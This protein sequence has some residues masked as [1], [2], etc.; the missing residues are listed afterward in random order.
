MS[1]TLPESASMTPPR[2]QSA[3]IEHRVPSENVRFRSL[4]LIVFA[5][6]TIRLIVMGY[7]YTDQ[8]D[9]RQD[10]FRFGFETGRIARSIAR[11]DGF[12]SPLYENTGPTAW[13]TP[14]YPYIVAAFFKVFGIDTKA[15]AFAVL[16][17]NALTSALTAIPVFFFARQSFG[18]RVAKWASWTWALFPYAIYFPEERIWETWLA[19]LL[20]S[21]LFFITLKLEETDRISAWVGAGLLW[22]AGSLTSPV[23]L[24]VLPF[25]EARVSYVRHKAGKRWLLPNLLL[26]LVFVAAV[27]PWFVRNYRTFHA[28]IPFRDNMGIALRLSTKG[29]TDYWGP[30]ELGP[31]NSPAEWE[32]F[33]QLGELRYM[34]TKQHQAI[35]FIKAN[36]GWYAKTTLRR[37]FFIWTGY[38]SLDHSYLQQ[39]EWDPVNIVFCSAFTILALLGLRKAWSRCRSAAWPYA[40]VL[41][42]FPLIYY[43]TSPE[44]YYR[45]PLDPLMVVLAVYAVT[46]MRRDELV[47]A[48]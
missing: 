22:G 34:A 18:V 19:T 39:E 40:I 24:T 48:D 14:V 46:P 21:L 6:L 12:G 17:F 35:A 43:V 32:E 8:L 41:L 23:V 20:L 25:L 29:A 27:T 37:I 1:A 44:L 36:P 7:L 28:F 13:M 4:V 3:R 11:G 5:G 30:Y 47:A 45:R 9:P 33:K 26:A 42:T 31:W 16:S 15:A 10:H 2:G 38:W